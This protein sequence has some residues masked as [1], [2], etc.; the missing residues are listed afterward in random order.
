MASG[1]FYVAA[2]T[3]DLSK[4]KELDPH[5][6]AI[7]HL[8]G[9]IDLV[10]EAFHTGEGLMNNAPEPITIDI[11]RRLIW[12]ELRRVIG[13]LD[14]SGGLSWCLWLRIQPPPD[15]DFKTILPVLEAAPNVEHWQYRVFGP[16]K[17]GDSTVI[18]AL[19]ETDGKGV[20]PYLWINL[21][22]DTT[23]RDI[24]LGART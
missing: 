16:R 1:S 5:A 15:I 17:P 14:G 21:P 3:T 8:C 10:L 6:A 11:A 23:I 9:F 18:Y 4:Y 12:S 20:L 24:Q 19:A 7:E 2:M 22:T 13:D